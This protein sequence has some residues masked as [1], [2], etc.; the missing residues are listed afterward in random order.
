MSTLEL[1]RTKRHEIIEVAARH[2]AYDVRL[3]GSVVRGEDTPR[4]DIDVL[5]KRTKH[6]SSW[7]PAGLI[8]DL[9]Q[10]LNRR[11]D[12]VIESGLNEWMRERVL[13]E[14]VPL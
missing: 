6:T 5:I 12:V 13:H 4:S 10:L 8:L 1:L 2:G 14:A 3:F 7:F 9:E 11:V